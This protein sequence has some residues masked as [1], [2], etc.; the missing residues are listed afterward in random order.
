MEG[1][2]P[3]RAH[4][5]GSQPILRVENMQA[6][7]RFYVDVLGFENAGW[8]TDDFTSVV[9]DG[10][11]LYLCRGDQGRGGAWVWIG[12]DDVERLHQEC[13]ARGVT[14]RL[15]PTKRPWALEMQVEDPD[16]N[17]LRFGSEAK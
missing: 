4:F 7:L 1:K 13:E 14:I 3:S 5:E 12:V 6:S 17:V 11:G 2:N 10:A 8:G 15:P 16:G 9:R